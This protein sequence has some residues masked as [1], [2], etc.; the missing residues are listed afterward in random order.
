MSDM[1]AMADRPARAGKLSVGF[2]AAYAVSRRWLERL[3][4]SRCLA[5]IFVVVCLTVGGCSR[6]PQP[7]SPFGK[8][9]YELMLRYEASPGIFEISN[10]ICGTFDE[11]DV[12]VA[13]NEM[14]ELNAS[15]WGGRLGTSW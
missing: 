11:E 2:S 12:A 10:E 4:V 7:Q 1:G 14:P 6:P 9:V 13:V 3:I 15:T 8:A 5:P